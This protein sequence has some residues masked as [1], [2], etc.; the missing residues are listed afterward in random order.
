MEKK[1]L[2]HLKFDN[3]LFS[4]KSFFSRLNFRFSMCPFSGMGTL[5]PSTP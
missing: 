5:I 3:Q 2:M 4:A 1:C